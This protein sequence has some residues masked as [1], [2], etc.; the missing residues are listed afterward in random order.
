MNK[1][2][3]QGTRAETRVEKLHQDQGFEAELIRGRGSRDTADVRVVHPKLG[4]F[5]GSV[6]DREHLSAPA[7]LLRVA[8]RSGQGAERSVLFWTQRYRP[9]PEAKRRSTRRCVVISE[10][11]WLELLARVQR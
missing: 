10:A 4:T 2:K 7:E 6:K 5:V 11:L 3:D 9:T 1:P 8:A